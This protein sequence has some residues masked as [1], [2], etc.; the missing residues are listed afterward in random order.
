M[1]NIE[2]NPR[3]VEEWFE[4]AADTLRRL[5]EH[6]LKNTRSSWPE[7]IRE[8]HEAYGYDTVRL[9]IP[10]TSAAIDRMDRVMTWLKWLEPDEVRLVWLRANNVRWKSISYAFGVNRSTAWRY[11]VCALVKVASR[12]NSKTSEKVLQQSFCR[13]HESQFLAS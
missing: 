8:F 10:P 9:R 12:L 11:W 3:I 5:P 1:D 13:R 2:W 7:V 4:E 6:R